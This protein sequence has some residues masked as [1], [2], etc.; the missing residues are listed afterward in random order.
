MLKR[1][2]LLIILI[3]S[4]TAVV[5][6]QEPKPQIIE[7]GQQVSG[8]LADIS[9]TNR[10]QFTAQEGDFLVITMN[11]VVVGDMDSTVTV[12][13]SPESGLYLYLYDDDSGG[14]YNSL[15][16]M[17]VPQDG[18]YIVTA[19][20]YSSGGG[21]YVLTVNRGTTMP[22]TFDT[23]VDVTFDVEHTSFYFI[24]TGKAG[25]VVNLSGNSAGEIDTRLEINDANGNQVGYDDDSGENFDPLIT[26]AVLPADG[27]YLVTL[28]PYTVP[29]SGTVS[30]LLTPS[31]TKSLDEGP[32]VFVLGDKRYEDVASFEGVAGEQVRLSLTLQ[33]GDVI[34]PYLTLSQ[35]T[36]SFATLNANNVQNLVFD[37]VVPAD[38][39]VIVRIENYVN[40]T[41]ELTLERS[42]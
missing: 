12:E 26:G 4:L 31:Q 6:A 39:Q 35:G 21:D 38:G 20:T 28:L 2:F 16:A 22:L 30:I 10:Y 42:Q 37:V 18:T 15:L 9:A 29:A 25:D 33:S 13:S 3:V 11:A 34:S 40:A 5:Q 32:Q 36:D 17:I 8:N 1:A 19:G 27:D 14:N 41:M 7:I 23:P 24:F